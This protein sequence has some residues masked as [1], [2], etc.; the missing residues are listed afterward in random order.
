MFTQ[1]RFALFREIKNASNESLLL[2]HTSGNGTIQSN[3]V[4]LPP[5]FT[6]PQKTFLSLVSFICLAV[7]EDFKGKRTIKYKSL[8]LRL[9]NFSKTVSDSLEQKEYEPDM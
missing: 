2:Q 3:R 8:A 6:T 1:V 7:I 5:D 4:K 9:K